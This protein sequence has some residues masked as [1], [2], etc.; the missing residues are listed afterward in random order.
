M[1][2]IARRFMAFSFLAAFSVAHAQLPI[3]ASSGKT[4]AEIKTDAQKFSQAEKNY[5]TNFI[6]N[7]TPDTELLSCVLHSKTFNTC[8]FHRSHVQRYL[9]NFGVIALA[10]EGRLK[11]AWVDRYPS[12]TSI[13]V[14]VLTNTG[15]LYATDVL[16]YSVNSMSASLS[17][18]NIPYQTL[19]DSVVVIRNV[20]SVFLSFL[21]DA[22]PFLIIYFLWKQLSVFFKSGSERVSK[23]SRMMLADLAG[24][25]PIKEDVRDILGDIRTFMR[26]KDIAH[27]GMS[28]SAVKGLMLEGPPGNG[29]TLLASAIAGELGVAFYTLSGSSLVDVYA[30]LAAKKIRNTFKKARKESRGAVIFIDE[31]DA[32]AGKRSAG[33]FGHSEKEQALNELLVQMDG[34][35]QKKKKQKVIVIAATNRVDILDPALLRA[36]R[37]DR[38]ILIPN[39]DYTSR[40][41]LLKMYLK[42][43]KVS[44]HVS[45]DSLATLTSGCNAADIRRLVNEAI[46]QARKTSVSPLTMECFEDAFDKVYIGHETHKDSVNHEEERIVAYHECGHALVSLLLPNADRVRKITSVPRGTSLGMVVTIPDDKSVLLSK[47][48]MLAKLKVL[49]AG[50]AAEDIV[51]GSDMITSGASSDIEEATK[52]ARLMYGQLGLSPTIGMVKIINQDGSYNASSDMMHQF[53]IEIR[54]MIN[55]NYQEARNLLMENR[56]HLDTLAEVLMREK[57]LSGETARSL[58]KL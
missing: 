46:K 27:D 54:N 22:L 31:I 39:P 15:Y 4:D 52:L 17:R 16:A 10:D 20:F 36:E 2:L 51:F 49:L 14:Y 12:G 23:K 8:V 40:I 26:D 44:T 13:R 11:H 50:R 58:L 38:T 48:K 53:D 7:G 18:N 56:Q 47:T 41:A 21:M 3:E 55:E 32:F 43:V 37:F 25:E 57:T 45:L 42:S 30:G 19:D 29:K 1:S 34:V 33:Q 28:I 35:G 5:A 9:D 24:Y 6:D